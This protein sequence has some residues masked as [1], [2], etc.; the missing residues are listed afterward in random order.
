MTEQLSIVAEAQKRVA[1]TPPELKALR[2][3]AGLSISGTAAQLRLA[4]RQVEA[5]EL[6]EWDKLPGIAFIKGALRS[7]G[8]LLSADLGPLIAHVD[9]Q[10]GQSELK[11]DRTLEGKIPERSALGFGEGGKGNKWAWVGLALIGLA[12]VALF[13]GQG[14]DSYIPKQLI[15]P[16]KTMDLGRDASSA[17]TA[18]SSPPSAPSVTSPPAGASGKAGSLPSETPSVS[19]PGTDLSKSAPNSSV[20]PAAAPAAATAG[21]TPAIS[22]VPDRSKAS[23][24]NSTN[25]GGL[26]PG[27]VQYRISFAKDSWVE[28]KDAGGERV[29]YGTQV[30]GTNLVLKGKAPYSAVIGNAIHVRIEKKDGSTGASSVEQIVPMPKDTRQGIARLTIR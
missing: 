24:Q 6:G 2:E 19:A 10:L 28:I 12:A 1:A 14:L 17:A 29:L 22:S 3:A 26:V 7:Y 9:Q 4:A 23:E 21:V 13:F 20:A 8:R 11:A 30:A 27:E 15:P 25:A 16:S 18:S 5:L